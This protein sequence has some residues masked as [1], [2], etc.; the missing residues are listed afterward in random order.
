MAKSRTG[1]FDRSILSTAIKS[2]SFAP[3]YFFYGEEEFLITESVD[4]I[5]K[6]S[7]DE[8]VKE[9]NLDILQ[10]SDVDGDTLANIVSSYPMM[11]DRRVVVVKDFDKVSGKEVLESYFE[12]PAESTLLVL[13]TPRPDFRKKVYSLLKK[14]AVCGEFRPLYDNETVEWINLRM[15]SI[16]RSIEP[17]AA[18]LLHSYVGNSLRE[19]ANEI[20]KLSIASEGHSTITIQDVERIVGISKEFTVFELANTIGEKNISKSVVIAERLMDS[21]ESAVPVIA[22]LTSHFIK[23]W[24]LAYGVRQTKNETELARIAGIHPYFVRSY[25]SYVKNY[26]LQEIENAFV[27]LAEADLRIKSSFDSRLVLAQTITNLIH[28]FSE[29]FV[30]VSS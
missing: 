9:F 8:S 17:E 1:T 18:A 7:L 5:V 4:L 26:T 14:N 12:H 3:I 22:A 21:G 16:Q 2:Q 24:K 15:K 19:L 6:N 27:V 29:Q 10:G 28:S 25:L 20:E 23:M 30:D 11:A 13:T